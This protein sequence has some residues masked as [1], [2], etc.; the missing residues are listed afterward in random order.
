LEEAFAVIRKVLETVEKEEIKNNPDIK[1]KDEEDLTEK[2][3]RFSYE[4]KKRAI[5]SLIGLWNSTERCVWKVTRSQFAEDCPVDP[6]QRSYVGDGVWDY[7]WKVD[8]L[9]NRS[10]RPFGQIA[11]DWEQVLCDMAMR[12]L[13]TIPRIVTFGVHVDGLFYLNH[14]DANPVEEFVKS[15]LYPSGKPMFQIKEEPWWKV[16]TWPVDHEPRSFD[17]NFSKPWKK[18]QE[19]DGVDFAQKIFENEGGMLLGKAGTGKTWTVNRLRDMIEADAKKRGGN[20]RIL[21]CA[22]RHAAKALLRNGHTISHLLHKYKDAREFWLIIDE[23]SEPP[24]CM[25]SDIARW[26]LVGVKFV[27]CGDFEG[28]LLPMFDRWGDAMKKVDIQNSDFMH[29][30]VNGLQLHL[31]T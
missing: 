31:T 21:S 23:A 30:L 6:A 14:G 10:M 16:P 11:L 9:D 29:S 28:Q 22:L 2:A 7:K 15:K 12:A 4:S 17:P 24:M 13:R 5:L 18:F 8:I 1:I 27:V 26:K 25:W 20:A 19:T 3:E